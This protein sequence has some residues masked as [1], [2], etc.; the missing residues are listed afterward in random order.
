MVEKYLKH[1]RYAEEYREKDFEFWKEVVFTY[2]NKFNMFGYD[3]EL[4]V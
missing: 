2:E 4:R 1:L 3:G